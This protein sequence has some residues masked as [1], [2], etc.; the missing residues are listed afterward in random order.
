[1]VDA[2]PNWIHGTKGNP[3]L[4]LAKEIENAFSPPDI[5]VCVL[6]EDG[7]QLPQEEAAAYSTIMW[8]II[9]A[10]FH[11]SNKHCATISPNESLWD[12]FQ[13]E[14]AR[15]IPDTKP[16]FQRERDM[17]FQISESWGAFVGSHI[18]SQSLKYFWLEECIEGGGLSLDLVYS[19]P[20]SHELTSRVS[21]E[22]LL[23]RD[24]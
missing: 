17:I 4:D 22:P 2:G 18:F 6:D 7:K 24:I 15:R 23:R 5:G 1:M 14:V 11:Y 16:N 10:A 9:E 13:K 21:R 12:F 3:I 20:L 19:A 8:D